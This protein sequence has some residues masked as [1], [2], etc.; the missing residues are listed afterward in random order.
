MEQYLNNHYKIEIKPLI[1]IAYKSFPQLTTHLGNLRS[2]L[3]AFA[4]TPNPYFFI[5]CLGKPHW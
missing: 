3:H 1:I 4:T 5:L 2:H